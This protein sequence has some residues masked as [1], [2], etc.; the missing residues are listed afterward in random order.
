M[1][2]MSCINSDFPVMSLTGSV[3]W[4]LLNCEIFLYLTAKGHGVLHFHML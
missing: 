1:C 3:G 4:G 2:Q